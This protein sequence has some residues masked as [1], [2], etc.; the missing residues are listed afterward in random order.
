MLVNCSVLCLFFSFIVLHAADSNAQSTSVIDVLAGSD[1]FSVLLRHLQRT[2]LV[3]LLNES[4][5][6]TLIAPTNEAFQDVPETAVTKNRLLFHILNSTLLVSAVEADLVAETFLHS[7][8]LAV[9]LNRPKLD[10]SDNYPLPVYVSSGEPV[11]VGN[12][13]IIE[14][15]LQASSNLVQVVNKLLDTPPTVCDFLNNN[16]QTTIFANL[17]EREFNCSFPML[18]TY[19][20]LLVPTDAAFQGLADAEL[21]YLTTTWG[22]DDRI[23]LLARHVLDSFWASPF[24]KKSV[25]ATALDGAKLQLD[26]GLAINGTSPIR[27]NVLASDAAIHLYDTFITP[28]GSLHSLITFTPEKICYGLGAHEFVDEI[29]FRKLLRLLNTTSTEPQTV[30]VPLPQPNDGP[31]IASTNSALYHFVY[32]QHDLDLTTVLN[33]NVLLETRS[34]H[35]KL[36]YG[37]QR[38]RL[39]ASE[40]TESIYLN[41][42]DRVATP[43]YKVGNT[44]V[45]GIHGSLDLPPALDLAV[46]SLFQSAQSATYLSNLGLLD[47]PTKKGWTVLLP[48]TLAWERL[49]LVKTYLESN[50]TALRGVM[51]SMIISRPFYSDSEAVETKLYNGDGVT[52]QT[53]EPPEKDA[54]ST[55]GRTFSGTRFVLGVGDTPF[56]VEL[57]NILTSSGVVHGVSDLHIPYQVDITP[58]H[59]L[60]SGNTGIFVSLLRDRGFGYVLDPD[61]SYTIL[62]PSDGVLRAGN[63]T[64]DTE[65]LDKLLRMHII[66]ANPVDEF[67]DHSAAVE[68]LEPGVH[69]SA[70]ELTTGLYLVDVVEGD[71]HEIRVLN[72]GDSNVGHAHNVTTVLYVD[73]FLNPDWLSNGSGGVL[74]PPFH[75]KTSVA[76]LLGIVFGAMLIFGV[77][78]C[79]LFV[80]LGHA[81]KVWQQHNAA[82]GEGGE[83]DPLLSRRNSRRLLSGTSELGDDEDGGGVT[84]YGGGGTVRSTHSGVRGTSSRASIISARSVGS[85]HSVSEPI[86]TS[87]VQKGREHGNHL[88]L[89]KV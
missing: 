40:G 8:N 53:L 54:V 30:F 9:E 35:K 51:E 78:S 88:N 71:G 15:D 42:R 7:T 68:T 21:S 32:G 13:S 24:I 73:R 14:C 84:T 61:N 87:R 25:I 10:K 65:H 31:R 67:L 70:K 44:T 86:S 39:V 18:Q 1:R 62:A 77:L 49:G 57:P 19:S 58:E 41:G 63:I 81:R 89:P 52:V 11:H 74:V 27:T 56:H 64:A 37:N 66:P 46:G 85:E 48:T 82:A 22:E 29:K 4:K 60:S 3:P 28:N 43:G 76:V 6:I 55:Q 2:G 79:A 12:A 80:Y 38:I 36:G 47:L 59:I 69:L 72:R 34:N 23:A 5:N 26:H 75:L 33:T 17:F 83:T 50:E 45:Y 20:T 16:P